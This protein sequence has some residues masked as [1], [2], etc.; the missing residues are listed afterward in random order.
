MRFRRMRF[1]SAKSAHDHTL[2]TSTSS[3]RSGATSQTTNVAPAPSMM[4]VPVSRTN[5]TSASTSLGAT[6]CTSTRRRVTGRSDGGA[7]LA[8]E[9]GDLVTQAR[10]LLEPEV[11]GGVVH[12]VLQGLDQAAEI[13][14]RH[15]GEVEHRRALRLTTPPSPAPPALRRLTV[16][17][18]QHLEDVGDLLA[19]GL[20]IDPVLLVVLE[21]RLA[22]PVGLGDRVT[23]RV[24]HLVGVHDHLTLDVAGRATDGLD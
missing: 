20:G 14:G 16:A 22:A 6:W 12:L 11:G 17:A 2:R 18:A 1:Q 5:V 9:L 21:L 3:P 19:H 15:V 24:G 4:G 23:H 8:L 10:R 13:V 7:E